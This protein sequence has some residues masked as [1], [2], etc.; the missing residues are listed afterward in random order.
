MIK[1]ALYDHNIN[2]NEEKQT[3]KMRNKQSTNMDNKLKSVPQRK[4]LRDGHK[5]LLQ[6]THNGFEC[7]RATEEC[8][9]RWKR[10]TP[11]S[12]NDM[13]RLWGICW[14]NI[15]SQSSY[16]PIVTQT[17]QFTHFPE[18]RGSFLSSQKWWWL[19]P[20]GFGPDEIFQQSTRLDKKPWPVWFRVD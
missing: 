3:N 4:L 1:Q 16:P 10:N 12:R 13:P 19:K 6:L 18:R 20:W 17:L 8:W 9:E 7:G 2:E 5:A 14:Y 15:E 11:V